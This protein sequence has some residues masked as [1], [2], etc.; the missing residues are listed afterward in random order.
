MSIIVII[1]PIWPEIN[2][3]IAF[4]NQQSNPR[5]TQVLP[6]CP[7]QLVAH[8]AKGTKQTTPKYSSFKLFNR[9]P[10]AQETKE[11]PNSVITTAKSADRPRPTGHF[12]HFNRNQ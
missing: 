8:T 1:A 9:K 11:H 7:N 2:I 6:P 3:T 5:L 10:Q 4:S 12:P